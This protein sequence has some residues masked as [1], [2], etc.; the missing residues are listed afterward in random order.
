MKR[1]LAYLLTLTSLAGVVAAYPPDR[2]TEFPDN[3]YWGD[4]HIHTNL[5]MDAYLAGNRALGPEEAYRFAQGKSVT[6]STGLVA[7]LSRPLDFVVIAE[8][9]SNM[10]VMQELDAVNPELLQ[11]IL[12]KKWMSILKEINR[13]AAPAPKKSTQLSLAL[14]EAS[15]SEG[16]ALSNKAQQ[17]IW[18]R[19]AL[20]ADQFNRP[21]QFT[22]FIGYEWTQT[23]YNL[24]RVVIYKD[25]AETAGKARPFS[26][27]DSS[28]P[29]DLW[30]FMENYERDRGGE[31][32]AIPHN[33]NLSKGVMF[34]LED[35][36]GQPLS[37]DYAKMRNRWEPLFEMTQVKGD[38]ETHPSLS[39]TDEFA[40]Y[41]RIEAH[42]NTNDTEDWSEQVKSK[43]GAYPL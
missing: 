6:T 16:A 35:T 15:L 12:G 20:L 19:S 2:A 38:S 39:V 29:E 14:T 32:L 13:T 31:V 3:V 33:G 25:G 26:Q 22:A 5:S 37:S 10:G 40:D 42:G 9:A 34:A 21:G 36:K 4:T 28:D 18:E 8:H 30:R 17:T 43:R 27:F 23:F 24:H 11:T 7:K 41:E 1:L